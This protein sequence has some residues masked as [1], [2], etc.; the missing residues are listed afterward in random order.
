[1]L[2]KLSLFLSEKSYR[3]VNIFCFFLFL[4]LHMKVKD[5]QGKALATFSLF[6]DGGRGE[7]ATPQ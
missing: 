3:N 1:M 4:F 7:R 2:P 6:P 5:E